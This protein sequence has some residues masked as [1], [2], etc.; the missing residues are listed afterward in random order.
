MCRCNKVLLF[1]LRQIC[2]FR[3]QVTYEATVYRGGISKVQDFITEQPQ[4]FPVII[5][6]FFISY[7]KL[8][9]YFSNFQ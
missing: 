8:G 3:P 2:F 5:E 1:L 9:I 6:E 4:D 7:K